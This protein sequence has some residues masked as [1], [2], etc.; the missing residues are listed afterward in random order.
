M[1][2]WIADSVGLLHI[3][4][5]MIIISVVMVTIASML[6]KKQKET[7]TYKISMVFG[8]SLLA[9]LFMGLIIVISRG[10]YH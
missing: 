9:T 6:H 7:K 3:I 10:K 8:I 4:P 2:Y 1:Q 5:L